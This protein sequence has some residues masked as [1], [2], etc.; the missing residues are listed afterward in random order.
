MKTV[1]DKQILI[2]ACGLLAGVSA[3]GNGENHAKASDPVFYVA[4]DG[5]DANAG[6]DRGCPLRTPQAAIDAVRRLRAGGGNANTVV[7]EFADGVY[8]LRRP[9]ELQESDG[10][11]LGNGEKVVW[12]AHRRG[13][14]VFSGVTK[15]DWMPLTDEKI[16]SRLPACARGKVVVA[17]IPGQ[18][19]LPSFLH[20]SHGQMPG[21]GIPIAV[22]SGEERLPCARFPNSEFARTGEVVAESIEIGQRATKDAS[23]KYDRV[24]LE[25]WAKE[26]FPWLFG[27]WGVE[28]CE[29]HSPFDGID[30]KNGTVS[31]KRE[32]IPFG[33]KEN[34]RFYVYNAF[35]ELDK[36]GEWVV[37]RERRIVYL[38]PKG[39]V[40]ADI[41][42]SDGL[43]RAVN[44]RN[45]ILD[46]FVLEKTRLS[47]VELR[48]CERVVVC[49]CEIR[50]TCSWGVRVFGGR[51]CRVVGCDAFDL[52][53]G[54]VYLSGGKHLELERADH[55]AVN[56]N[57]HHYG[58]VFYNYRQGVSLNGVGCSASHNLIHHSL[59]TGVY[60]MGNDHK[61]A[62]NVIHDTCEFNADAGAIYV[63]N[64][65]FVRRGCVIEHNVIHMTGRKIHP[66]DTDAIYLDDYSPENVVRY[67][68][69]NRATRGVHLAGGQ[70]NEV[71][72]NVMLNCTK[73]IDLSTRQPWANSQLG[74]K[75]VNYKELDAHYAVYSSDKWRRHYPGLCKL[76]ALKDPILAHHAYWNVISNNVSAYCG[77][78]VRACWE[79][80]S[81]TTVW[82]ENVSCGEKDPGL[83]DYFSFDWS[84]KAD[85]TYANVINGCEFDRAG[86]FESKH[87]FSP[88]VKFGKGVTNPQPWGAVSE[89]PVARVGCVFNGEL[90]KGETAFVGETKRC[91]VPGWAKGRRTDVIFGLDLSGGQSWREYD[92]SFVPTCDSE[93]VIEVMGGFGNAKTTYD[94]ISVKGVADNRELFNACQPFEANDKNRMRSRTLQC[95]KGERVEVSFRAC[96]EREKNH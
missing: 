60:A 77:E 86:L 81:N 64:Y 24:K 58:K 22:F 78:S 29:Q 48:D 63:W 55:A 74:R 84:A 80:V 10:G 46:G 6:T 36:P 91:H 57:I 40:P 19:A 52:G 71:Y 35:S 31:M 42:L 47:A 85:A 75:S 8:Q 43:V 53:E 62:W 9:V 39:D 32:Y 7:I 44:V 90:P 13:G 50:H 82:T 95:K 11:L 66:S 93:F 96:A 16:L 70:C 73:P 28:W 38:W 72:G 68:L 67:N 2:M 51:M 18:G 23:F 41:V 5:D 69:I 45:F 65:S 14:A 21:Q 61:I 87:R 17:Q 37:D 59:H 20:G 89:P 12:R 92:F 25:E 34:K 94:L 27:L 3:F 79:A 1:R 49:G 54:G 76:L 33:L 56:N 83:K 26:P 88:P 4:P 30:E 15:V